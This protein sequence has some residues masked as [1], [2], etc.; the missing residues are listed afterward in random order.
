[1]SYENKSMTISASSYDNDDLASFVQLCKIIQYL[2]G[3]GSSRTI[4]VHVDGDGSAG[5]RFDFGETDVSKVETPKEE[6]EGYQIWIG[7]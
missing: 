6:D 3:V 4:K 7:E 2:C 5:L 1:M